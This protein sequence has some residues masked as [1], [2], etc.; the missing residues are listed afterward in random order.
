MT[1]G[2]A[3][4][5]WIVQKICTYICLLYL[6]QGLPLLGQAHISVRIHVKTS[7]TTNSNHNITPKIISSRSAN[8]EG[9]GVWTGEHCPTN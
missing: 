2:G 8:G 5:D 4:V 3:L 1:G 7:C 9:K 6:I